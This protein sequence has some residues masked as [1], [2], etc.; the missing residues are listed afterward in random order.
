[1][2]KSSVEIAVYNPFGLL[3][4]GG[5]E[6]VEFFAGQGLPARLPVNPIK[7][8]DGQAGFLAERAR[9][10]GFSAAAAA[11]EKDSLVKGHGVFLLIAH[12]VCS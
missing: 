11:D 10:G 3:K 2:G 5:E 7:M 12:F 6:R 8:H 1:M 4:L 9:K